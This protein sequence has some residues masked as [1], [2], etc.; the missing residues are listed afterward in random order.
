MQTKGILE[1]FF[2]TR[3]FLRELK[4]R[5]TRQEVDDPHYEGG[6][7]TSCHQKALTF[8]SDK[9]IEDAA[10]SRLPLEKNEFEE[11]ETNQLENC[12]E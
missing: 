5:R 12:G 1:L 11:S 7:F 2:L 9:F 4:C 3:N 6:T 8:K 10:F